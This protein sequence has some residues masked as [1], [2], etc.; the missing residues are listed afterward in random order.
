MVP[1]KRVIDGSVAAIVGGVSGPHTQRGDTACLSP[2]GLAASS[3][4]PAAMVQVNSPRSTANAAMESGRVVTTGPKVGKDGSPRPE[5]GTT[6]RLPHPGD[7]RP[8]LPGLAARCAMEAVDS[9]RVPR[10]DQA[11]AC[12]DSVSRANCGRTVSALV[13]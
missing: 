7:N 6:G 2:A 10:L 11:G 3:G 13:A 4:G 8:I 5:I 9:P 12:H 1:R